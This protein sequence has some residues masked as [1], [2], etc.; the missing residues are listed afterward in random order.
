[1]SSKSSAAAVRIHMAATGCRQRLRSKRSLSGGPSLNWSRRRNVLVHS[2]LRSDSL[3]ATHRSPSSDQSARAVCL[4]TRQ[5]ADHGNYLPYFAATTACRRRLVSK[6][7]SGRQACTHPFDA[8]CPNLIMPGNLMRMRYTKR[9]L[10][11][12]LML[13]AWSRSRSPVGGALS[14]RSTPDAVSPVA[15]TEAPYAGL[16]AASSLL[17]ALSTRCRRSNS[18]Q[19]GTGVWPRECLAESP[20]TA[21]VCLTHPTRVSTKSALTSG[22]TR[23]AA[24][25]QAPH[26]SCVCITPD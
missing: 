1:M 9:G 24:A 26:M 10:D 19:G 17:M 8:P 4:S 18:Q 22:W 25:A 7:R 15:S 2:D 20:P 11:G 6:E 14:L 13:Y 16:P 21:R 23:Q 5:V 3:I 12:I